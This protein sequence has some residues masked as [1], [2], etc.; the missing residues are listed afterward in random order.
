MIIAAHRGDVLIPAGAAIMIST[1]IAIIVTGEV[2]AAAIPADIFCLWGVG[3]AYSL[4][5]AQG[6]WIPQPYFCF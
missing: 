6:Y 2:T 5:A 1:L 3:D 4:F